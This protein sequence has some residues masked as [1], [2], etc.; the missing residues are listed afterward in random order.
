MTTRIAEKLDEARRELL[1]LGMRNP[2][3]NFRPSK[4]R[5]LEI[6]SGDPDEILRQLVKEGKSLPFQPS[7]EEARP[8]RLA[9]AT[10][11]AR[12]QEVLLRTYYAASTYIEEQ[13]VNV[14]F[15]ALGMLHWYEQESS[16]DERKAPLLLVPVSIER[17]GTRERFLLKHTGEDL[18]ENLSLMTKLQSEFLI[19]LPG[20]PALEDLDLSEYFQAVSRAVDGQSRWR[21]EPQEMVLGFF[22]FGK[23]LMYRD[24]DESA[25]PGDVRPSDHLIM[26]SLLHE[27]FREPPTRHQEGEFLDPLPADLYGVLDADSSQVRA[28]LDVRDGRNL[29]IQGPPGTGK[30]QTIANIIANAIGQGKTVLFVSEKRAA[31]EVVKRR[32]DQ[33]G[34]GD[35]CLELHSHKTNKKSVLQ[36]LSRTLNLGRPSSSPFEE[37]L[38]IH[39][40]VRDRLNA[41]RE[42]LHTP[43]GESGVTPFQAM[44]EV[45]ELRGKFT[46]LP[47]LDGI[48]WELN[49]GEFARAYQL[50]GELQA[51]LAQMGAYGGHPFF[52][53]KRQTFL[54]HQLDEL[55]HLI[56]EA[57][58]ALVA[59]E[60]TV[61]PMAD[62]LCYGI[63]NLEEVQGLCA[64]VRRLLEAP[65]QE[66][67]AFDVEWK[68]EDLKTLL[69]AGR[70]L[71]EIQ[72]RYG[73][74]VIP[75]AWE[76]DP[77][78][79][80][81][82]RQPLAAYGRR[83]WKFVV[84]PY[85]QARNRLLGF[86]RNEPQAR[87]YV[88]IVDAIMDAHR[89][90]AVLAQ[91]EEWAA[92]LFGS[93]W[94]RRQSD[95]DTLERVAQWAKAIHQDIQDG[96]LPQDLPTYLASQHGPL[97]LDDVYDA[98][99]R[100][101]DAMANLV[102]FLDYEGGLLS[103]SFDRQHRFLD[104][105]QEAPE[106]LTEI[107]QFNHLSRQIRERRLG[108]V[109]VMAKAWDEAPEHL[110]EAF[111]Y[112]WLS[113]LLEQTF[114]QR[115]ALAQFDGTSHLQAIQRFRVLDGK[116][117]EHHRIVL[118]ESHWKGLPK[119][120]AGGQV[121]V[122]RHE[123]EKKVRH[124]PIRQLMQRAGNAILAV[125]PVFMMSPLSIATFLPPASVT[126]DLVVFDEA[127]QVRP[128]D[129][130]GAILRA[131][132][133]VVV[134]DKKQMPPMDFFELIVSNNEDSVTGDIESILGLFEGAGAPVR[135]LQWHYR[136]RHESLIAVSNQCFYDNRLV[137]FPSPDR[138][139]QDTGLIYRHIPDAI[140]DYGNSRTNPI[141]AAE[142]AKAVI[143]HAKTS[144][145]KTL[146]VVAFSAAQMHAIQDQVEYLRGEDPECEA[147][148]STHPHEPFFIKNLETV[149]GDERD[150]ILIS[151]GYGRS[152]DGRLS[153]NF[154]PL[155]RQGGERRLNVLISRARLRCEVFTNL[156]SKDLDVART[157]AM[158]I[159]ALKQYLHYAET[160]EIE[161]EISSRTEPPF[162]KQVR[163]LLINRG[164]DV[165]AN[166]GTG[167]CL[168]LA[169]ADPENPAA[170]RLGLE[171]D[172]ENYLTASSARDRDRL[173]VQALEGLRWSLHRLWI[174]D[175]Y[176][177]QE[178]EMNR[179]IKAI[180]SVPVVEA[181]VV[182]ETPI[183]RV[184]DDSSPE[185]LDYV[186]APLPELNT[187]ITQMPIN[188]LAGLVATV[189]QSES[190]VHSSEVERRISQAS[191]SKKVSLEGAIAH[192][193]KAG[194]V[195]QRG[196]FLWHP[197]MQEPPVRNRLKLM[198]QSRRLEFVAPEEI[199]QA[200]LQI[201]T[202]S[203]GI[204][205]SEI[206]AVACR[207]LGF[208]RTSEEM[209][210]IME[211]QIEQMLE[212]GTLVVQGDYLVAS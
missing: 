54:P 78:E 88:K 157:N 113:Y 173:R 198:P 29:V 82:M 87:H 195:M 170:Y 196:E 35:A 126:F 132:Q 86:C 209:Y 2:L 91:H 212:E 176:R 163:E 4:T 125:K 208:V 166:V 188:H 127:S 182:P 180:E 76:L 24:L 27:G 99:A 60:E 52:G 154:G 92:P 128:V 8:D 165:D 207:T 144:P 47:P 33:V 155:N 10:P 48:P 62:A 36:E 206:P 98:V 6:A 152:A 65:T 183:T 168:D 38:R 192:A 137:V 123:F 116:Q 110:S 37:D 177:D 204:A 153:M 102:A 14:L 164:V 84:N 161:R 186:V 133:V 28:M 18:V 191:G 30:S 150:V 41:Y 189:V 119:H 66:T 9:T 57:K 103:F 171:A 97:D 134:G 68:A 12:L 3:L 187:D 141:E 149:Q 185:Q 70:R 174:T 112:H 63:K 143:E 43:M 203:C 79:L 31:L 109:L 147:F 167:Y 75:E 96:I 13:G 46:D 184:E 25:W 160:G 85:R 169:I 151:I 105:W 61:L 15:L 146:G 200:I 139:R 93:L 83:W 81:E 7:D 156:S 104:K 100:Y 190:P 69:E 148:F 145:E 32:L 140:Y 17:S 5:G 22:S 16:Q 122:L 121:G 172:G 136:S 120:E 34:L 55:T 44:A 135:M 162:V 72:K 20:L 89:L 158:G 21:V 202:N 40:E 80:L 194:S 108:G 142:V 73:R 179:L 45:M 58:G 178:R 129:A 23:F 74:A 197:E 210:A 77:K 115:P 131:K 95:W 138:S 59:L 64:I 49:S 1:D 199:S 211:T 71:A 117:I 50:V 124:L 101:Q 90:D 130:F 201:V 111:R 114:Q 53:A 205:R 106:R 51:Y 42:A 193:I 26:R 67:V 118:A 159:R 56:G 39:E 11:A 181:P 94:Q 19:E 107:T 175:W